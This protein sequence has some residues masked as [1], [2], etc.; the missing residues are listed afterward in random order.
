MLDV[1]NVFIL[2]PDSVHKIKYLLGKRRIGHTFA[3]Q[4]PTDERMRAIGV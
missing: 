1:S 3:R 4:S 2:K